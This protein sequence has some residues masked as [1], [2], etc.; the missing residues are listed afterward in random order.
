MNGGDFLEFKKKLEERI[1]NQSDLL[2]K[3]KAE[4]VYSDARTFLESDGDTFVKYLFDSANK[5]D[6]LLDSLNLINDF[7]TELKQGFDKGIIA[8]NGTSG[9]GQ[10]YVMKFI[11]QELKN[12]GVSFDRIYLLATRA[13]RSNEGHKDP[14]IFVNKQDNL[15]KCIFSGESFSKDDVYLEYESRPG[16]HNVILKADLEKSK[17]NL[18]YLETVIP[19]LLKMQNE[20]INGF[21]ALGNNLKIAYLA[22]DSGKEWLYR[23]VAREP[24]KIS[25]E[26]FRNKLIGRVDSSLKDMYVASENQIPS[27]VHV[28]DHGPDTAKKVLTAWNIL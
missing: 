5:Y 21:D 8:L 15:Y 23:L 27:V 11:E 19:T 18:M 10:S 28:L 25:D 16:A 7:G 4:E 6:E 20:S 17:D 24:D 22:A 14:Y 2:F 1:R 12:K 9:V 26:S 13:P 3:E